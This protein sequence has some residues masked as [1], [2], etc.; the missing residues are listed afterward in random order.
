MGKTELGHKNKEFM[1]FIIDDLDNC[2]STKIKDGFID[3][4]DFCAYRI[5]ST[6]LHGTEKNEYYEY[7]P[8]AIYED[9]IWYSIFNDPNSELRLL[10]MRIS[11]LES[12]EEKYGKKEILE[13][14]QFGMGRLYEKNPI[15][16]NL[17]GEDNPF[18]YISIDKY[19][20]LPVIKKI[21][22]DIKNLSH[23]EQ[24]CL[25]TLQA[26]NQKSL[27][28]SLCLVLGIIR[29]EEFVKA[30]LS[31][32]GELIELMP[33]EDGEVSE[34]NTNEIQRLARHTH[35]LAATTVNDYLDHFD[36][37]NEMQVKFLSLVKNHESKTVELKS[38]FFICQK[39][40][41]KL[42]KIPHSAVK[43]IAGF[44]NAS[45]GIL[46]I[47]VDDNQEFIGLEAAEKKQYKNDDN[48]QTNINS[49]IAKLIGN[50]AL[51]K[52]KFNFVSHDDKRFLL[53]EVKSNLPSAT[54]VFDQKHNKEKKKLEKEKIFYL[55]REKETVALDSYETT[56]YLKSVKGS[57][58]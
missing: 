31:F 17:S 23:E 36:E 2:R 16:G 58:R 57:I 21:I 37:I 51:Q 24:A 33:D 12:L 35:T 6:Q 18:E 13:L 43:T 29:K 3:I 41:N 42:N 49:Y 53:I 10:S 9:E 48:Y 30:M 26:T 19:K 1:E 47:G 5:F 40:N 20:K 25:M 52:I 55:R 46:I 11:V 50:V 8:H 45:G 4:Q 14:R 27:I 54:W 39:T 32:H 15:R 34:E 7:Y 44:M 56:E 22:K 38:S 28:T